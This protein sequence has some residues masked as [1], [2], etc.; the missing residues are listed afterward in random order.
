M[1]MNVMVLSFVQMRHYDTPAIV[2][3]TVRD[4][5]SYCE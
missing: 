2:F 3:L 5:E 1:R 4:K